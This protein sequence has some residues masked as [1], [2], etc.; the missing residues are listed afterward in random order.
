VGRCGR[1]RGDGVEA[2]TQPATGVAGGN[3][4]AHDRSHAPRI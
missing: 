3:D 1:L 4:H 2:G